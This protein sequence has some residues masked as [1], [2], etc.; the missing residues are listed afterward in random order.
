M[1]P[2]ITPVV[3]G[4]HRKPKWLVAILLFSLCASLGSAAVGAAVALLGTGV[5][6]A[7]GVSA[8]AGWLG[9]G[10]VALLYSLHELK[11]LRLPR[12]QRNWQV[13]SGWRVKLHPWL[14]AGLYGLLLGFGVLTRISVSTFYLFLLWALLVGDI[15]QVIP[16]AA[17]FGAAQGLPLFIAG[18]KVDSCD[19]A[20]R[21]GSRSWSLRPLVHKVNS[22]VLAATSICCFVAVFTRMPML[23]LLRRM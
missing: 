12:P 15:R 6:L 7:L 11:L 22:G 19:D 17:I 8:V 4:S 16:V 23:S 10:V 18:W 13:P 1:I 21:I 2:S 14:T 3:Y 20:Y 5:R 9:F